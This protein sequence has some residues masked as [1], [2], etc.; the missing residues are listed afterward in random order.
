MMKLYSQSKSFFWC[1][2][3][4]LIGET[5]GLAQTLQGKLTF[6]R[7]D[8]VLSAFLQWKQEK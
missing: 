2:E 4:R 8:Q 5:N 3:D 7:S 6:D 1:D